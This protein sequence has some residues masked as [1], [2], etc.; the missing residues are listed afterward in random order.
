MVDDIAQ[1]CI[2]SREGD[3]RLWLVH[4]DTEEERTLSA[5]LRH[6]LHYAALQSCPR[7]ICLLKSMLLHVARVATRAYLMAFHPD[8]TSR[9]RRRML[10]QTLSYKSVVNTAPDG[11][12]YQI[13]C[14]SRSLWTKT[15]DPARFRRYLAAWKLW[16]TDVCQL[17][18]MRGTLLLFETF[19]VLGVGV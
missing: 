14:L 10:S 5:Q 15:V 8:I 7:D 3:D 6:R 2:F 17:C 16:S 13:S 4:I 9:R 19:P 18:W 12:P 1:D 11:M